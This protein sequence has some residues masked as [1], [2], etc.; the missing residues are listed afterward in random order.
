MQENL[1]NKSDQMPDKHSTWQVDSFCA[2][3][4]KSKP[5]SQGCFRGEAFPFFSPGTM[6]SIRGQRESTTGCVLFFFFSLLALLFDCLSWNLSLSSET[7]RGGPD[8]IWPQSAPLLSFKSA[9]WTRPKNKWLRV[10]REIRNVVVVCIVDIQPTPKTWEMFVFTSLRVK[11][12][13]KDLFF[14]GRGLRGI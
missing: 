7:G 1:H 11:T 8:N 3:H 13:G 9:Y 10:R 5:Y 6:R 4:W 2:Y 14:Q 12:I